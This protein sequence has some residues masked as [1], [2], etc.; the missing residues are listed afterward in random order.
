[1]K[2]QLLHTNATRL[3]ECMQGTDPSRPILTLMALTEWL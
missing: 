2:K 3:N 1:M